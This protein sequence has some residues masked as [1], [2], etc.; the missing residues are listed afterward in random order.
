MCGRKGLAAGRERRDAMLSVAHLQLG[1]RRG[2]QRARGEE[3]EPRL[4][5]LSV[6]DE[7][8]GRGSRVRAHGFAII[9]VF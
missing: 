7:Q 6:A 5:S 1:R 4:A 3:R 8:T 2:G 9:P